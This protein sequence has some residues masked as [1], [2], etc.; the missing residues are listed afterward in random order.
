MP[1]KELPKLYL[2]ADLDYAGGTHA[3]SRYLNDLADAARRFESQLVIQ[4]RAKCVGGPVLKR[5][6]RSARRIV[7][8]EA[9]LALNGPEDLAAELGYDGVHWP[10]SLIPEQPHAHTASLT[11]RSSAVH[12][13]E[14]VRR[15]E[16]G[17]ATALVYSPVFQPTWKAAVPTGL[18]ALSQAVRATSLPVYALGGVNLS[19]IDAC[20]AAGAYGVAV[21]SGVAGSAHPVSECARYLQN[22][23]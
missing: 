3:L 4:V 8:V 1:S 15:A 14:A 13:V 22:L 2:I 6:A 12:S 16:R 7:G 23:H 11:F 21:L 10:E 17:G 9:L 19:R 20:R 18:T 5:I